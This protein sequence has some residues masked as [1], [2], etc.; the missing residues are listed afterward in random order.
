VGR[1]TAAP[2][3]HGRLVDSF[4]EMQNQTHY[5]GFESSCARCGAGFTLTAAAQ[6]H[7]HEELK[8]PIKRARAAG[9]C[10]TCRATAGVLERSQASQDQLLR[11]AER[12]KAAASERPGDAG[13]LLEYAVAKLRVLEASWSQRSAER[14]LGEIRRVA[15]LDPKLSKAASKREAE[16]RELIDQHRARPSS[17]S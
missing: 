8:I 5:E 13:I 11:A 4:G 15:K 17:A 7:I 12:A 3:D 2:I 1:E 6:R 16:L 9:S 10:P 14:L